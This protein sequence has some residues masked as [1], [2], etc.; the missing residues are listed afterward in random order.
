LN[1]D[2]KYAA[3]TV[4]RDTHQIDSFER[5]VIDFKSAGY[6]MEGFAVND[7]KIYAFMTKALPQTVEAKE[8][9]AKE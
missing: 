2:G 5:E 1:N 9:K 8:M 3:H 6:T 4:Y 7:T